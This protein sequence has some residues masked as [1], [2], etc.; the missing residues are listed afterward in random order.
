M[1]K[2]IA[3]T[4]IYPNRTPVRER[5][6]RRGDERDLSMTSKKTVTAADGQAAITMLDAEKRVATP[7]QRATSAPAKV[8]KVAAKV[9]AV[10][11][12]A[13]VAVDNR[14]LHCRI[15]G[16]P[17]LRSRKS[18]RLCAAHEHA[19]AHEGLRLTAAGHVRAL[20]A[21]EERKAAKTSPAPKANARRADAKPAAPTL[22]VVPKS[23]GT[24]PAVVGKKPAQRAPEVAPV[25]VVP[26]V[27]RVS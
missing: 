4:T 15:D 22:T 19:Y 12:V 20:V 2:A 16:C 13:K 10:V 17:E 9:A 26:T 23:A 21:L 25:P 3:M 8:A 7:K 11:A 6:R 27:E 5:S 18:N 1:D 24:S 14:T